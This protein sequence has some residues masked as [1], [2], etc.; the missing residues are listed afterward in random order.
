M[1]VIFSEHKNQ[2]GL[3]KIGRWM[4]GRTDSRTDG[5]MDEWMDEQID[6]QTD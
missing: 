5:R 4:D 6:R 2:E 1:R 3:I